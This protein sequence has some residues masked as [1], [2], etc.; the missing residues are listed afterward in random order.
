MRPFCDWHERGW[1]DPGIYCSVDGNTTTSIPFY[2]FDF[3]L[4]LF[5]FKYYSNKQIAT[6]HNLLLLL[7]L[8]LFYA[9]S[10]IYCNVDGHSRGAK[11]NNCN[12]TT[13][14]KRTTNYYNQATTK[15]HYCTACIPTVR[16][17]QDTKAGTGTIRAPGGLIV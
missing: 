8:L 6:T 14:Y 1:R 16:A 7:L 11:L 2:L 4:L 13:L 15:K 3:I 5:Y 10:G 12:K 9:R 17:R